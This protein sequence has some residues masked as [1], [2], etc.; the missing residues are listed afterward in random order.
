M[1]VI[2]NSHQLDQMERVC[3]RAAFI[4]QGRVEA[5]QELHAPS[6][7][8]ERALEVRWLEPPQLA[9]RSSLTGTRPG[10]RTVSDTFRRS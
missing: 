10:R 9:H 6:G 4:K 3:D 1:S 7:E 5:V 8:L 2:L